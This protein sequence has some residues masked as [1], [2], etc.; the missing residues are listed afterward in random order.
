MPEVAFTNNGTAQ[1]ES[2]FD[3]TYGAN[4]FS[5]EEMLA[6]M[7]AIKNPTWWSNMMMPGYAPFFLITWIQGSVVP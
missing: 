5:D 7:Q 3:W 1:L 4:V 6:T 2:T